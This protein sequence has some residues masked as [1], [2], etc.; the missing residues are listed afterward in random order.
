MQVSLEIEYNSATVTLNSTTK[1]DYFVDYTR[2][3]SK[4][5]FF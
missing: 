5:W 3:Y 4:N 2:M 1:S